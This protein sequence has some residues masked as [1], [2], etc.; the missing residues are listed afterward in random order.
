MPV[1]DPNAGWSV[2][3]LPEPLLSNVVELSSDGN[4]LVTNGK[5]YRHDRPLPDARLPW[6]EYLRKVRAYT[7]ICLDAS[8]RQTI[9][10]ENAGLAQSRWEACEVSQGRPVERPPAQ[11]PQGGPEDQPRKPK[12]QGPA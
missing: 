9:F 8:Q 6:K 11:A 2:G 4:T 12:K 5:I 10:L 1:F 7:T 3:P